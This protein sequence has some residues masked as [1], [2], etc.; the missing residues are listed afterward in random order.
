MNEPISALK[1]LWGQQL[2]KPITAKYCSKACKHSTFSKFKGTNK[3]PAQL[4]KQ[5]MLR[6]NV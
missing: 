1:A 5:E 6:S 4:K 2:L 3:P